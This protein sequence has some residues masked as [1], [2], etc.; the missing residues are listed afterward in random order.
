MYCTYIFTRER[1]VRAG[2]K[3]HVDVILLGFSA[4]FGHTPKG[5]F[6]CLIK[7]KTREG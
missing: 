5:V 3:N 2:S 6:Q 4:N 1:E 7:V